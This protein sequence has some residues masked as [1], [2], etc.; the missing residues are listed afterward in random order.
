M[1][2]CIVYRF[3]L[4][5]NQLSS[6]KKEIREKN[7]LEKKINWATFKA[8][9]SL[10]IV[11][12]RNRPKKINSNVPSNLATVPFLSHR[13]EQMKIIRRAELATFSH[14]GSWNRI[15]F[16]RYSL[17]KGQVLRDPRWVLTEFPWNRIPRCS[18]RTGTKSSSHSPVL[19]LQP[20]DT[21]LRS[22]LINVNAQCSAVATCSATIFFQIFCVFLR[23][24]ARFF[25]YHS[26][27]TK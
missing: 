2:G 6:W 14:V 21:L 23:N 10:I 9:S 20:L 5:I 27:D 18:R 3:P 22:A 15:V 19:P 12:M 24:I 7:Y 16:L 17:S 13:V 25:L 1:L 26:Y 11:W 4:W 8:R